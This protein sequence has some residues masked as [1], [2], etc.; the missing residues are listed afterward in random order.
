LLQDK[1][2][3]TIKP[4]DLTEYARNYKDP[5]CL[6]VISHFL[7][8]FARFLFDLSVTF[9]PFGGIYFMSSVLTNLEFIFEAP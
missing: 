9:L 3:S 4:V 5:L 2:I 1:D 7:Y 8:Y 6:A